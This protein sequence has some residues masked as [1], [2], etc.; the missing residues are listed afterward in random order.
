MITATLTEADL[1]YVE[2]N[3][4]T[5]GALCAGREE[6]TAEVEALIE[7][8]RLQ[9]PSYV[10]PDGTGMF[11]A[12]YFVLVDDAGGLE[13]LQGHFADRHRRASVEEQASS[14]EQDWQGYLDGTYGVCLRST[15]PEAIVR[16]S[17]LVSSL[18]VL[19]VLARPSD[20][21]WKQALR[22]Q[23]E[24]L[25]ALEREFAPDHDRDGRFGRLPTCDLL[26]EA[27]RERFPEVFVPEGRGSLR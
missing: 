8:R 7:Q 14:L 27:A 6:T 4:C 17:T 5:L 18:C 20:T 11:P 12:D 26:V 16:K 24:E 22:E 2:A 3:F 19:L 15:T 10:L 21:D 25:D 9:R 1:E 23:V 13:A